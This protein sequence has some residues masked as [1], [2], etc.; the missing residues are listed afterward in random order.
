MSIFQSQPR[1]DGGE[2]ENGES[3]HSSQRAEESRADHFHLRSPK[4]IV[5]F[6]EVNFV[7]SKKRSTTLN[8]SLFFSKINFKVKIFFLCWLNE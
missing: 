5:S 1:Q 2:G 4:A 8:V 3:H 7:E 6:D